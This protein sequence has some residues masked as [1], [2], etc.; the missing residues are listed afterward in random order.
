[1]ETVYAG[2]GRLG[3]TA[4]DRWETLQVNRL[5]H[6]RFKGS[7]ISPPHQSPPGE[8]YPISRPNYSAT[9][10]A[11]GHWVI[12]RQSGGNRDWDAPFRPS[13]NMPSCP[14]HRSHHQSHQRRHQACASFALMDLRS[15]LYCR[16]LKW[17]RFATVDQAFTDWHA[18]IS[19]LLKAPEVSLNCSRIEPRGWH[20]M[21]FS[22]KLRNRKLSSV[23]SQ[24]L[25]SNHQLITADMEIVFI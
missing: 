21:L 4:K 15:W 25:A 19:L 6:S 22:P 2:A 9:A 8:T 18:L 1:M 23:A 16:N 13:W 14:T 7:G 10:A 20:G 3:G 17:R 5:R 11:L 24:L 12:H